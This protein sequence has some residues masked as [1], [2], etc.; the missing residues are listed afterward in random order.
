MAFNLKY[1]EQLKA[2]GKIRGFTGLQEIVKKV[3]GLKVDKGSK[4]KAW[5]H[6]IL[7][8]FC[9]ANGLV[10]V[11]EFKFHP[12]RRYRFD[13]AITSQDRKIKCGIEYEGIFSEKS[14]HTTFQGY[15]NDAEKYNLAAASGWIVFRYTAKNYKTQLYNDLN[16]LL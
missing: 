9:D 13:F 10:L 14:R 8:T 15:S 6:L 7:K 2:A 11:T 16:K 12:R 3:K 4:N 5:I 1:L